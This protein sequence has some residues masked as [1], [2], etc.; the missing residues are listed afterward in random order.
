MSNLWTVQKSSEIGFRRIFGKLKKQRPVWCSIAC[1]TAK[2]INVTSLDVCLLWARSIHHPVSTPMG[3][4]WRQDCLF[5]R[6]S[7]PNYLRKLVVWFITLVG[8]PAVL[9]RHLKE[10]R[11]LLVVVEDEIR[12][13]RDAM[14]ES[15]EGNWLPFVFISNCSY[16]WVNAEVGATLEMD[17]LGILGSWNV[18]HSRWH[19][20]VT[21]LEFQALDQI[22]E[23]RHF[24]AWGPLV[25]V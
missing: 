24:Y 6:A 12:F 5:S 7:K 18:I 2:E 4:N 20:K 14:E 15:E 13:S 11:K 3:L 21:F 1:F 9:D 16:G 17:P 25:D 19:F 22:R 8:K 10:K 23:K